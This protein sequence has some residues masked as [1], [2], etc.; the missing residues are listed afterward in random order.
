MSITTI[1]IDTAKSVFQLHGVDAAGTPMLKR[2]LR[3]D[4][5]LPFFEKQERCVVVMEACGASHHW[6]RALI[7]LGHEVRLVPPEATRP[8]V[9]KGRKNDAADAAAIL[10]ASRHDVKFVPV[11]SREQQ[12]TLA[13][14][15]AR[16]MLVKQ[17]TMLVN[18]MRGLATEFGLVMP[19][20]IE[21][22][23]E[24]AADVDESLS[25]EEKRGFGEL[26]ASAAEL[27]L[28]IEAL[29]KEIVEHARRDQLA[30]RLATVPGIGPINASL[31]SATVGGN[32]GA[33]R[34]ARQFA[35]WLGL[36]PRQNST[37][38]KTRLGRITRAG[39]SEIRTMLVL[40]ATSMVYRAGNWNCA[41]GA[42]VRGMLARRPAKLV[43][44]ALA[45]KL[46]R[47][48]WA[49]MSRGEVYRADGRRAIAAS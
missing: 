32:A 30:R 33:F 28:H 38:G 49:V 21:R 46:A 18:A 23:V 25:G 29:E 3:R 5:L 9:K 45:N 41:T 42:W 40:G 19:K 7:A 13:L 48:A 31:I 39:N 6:G 22:L 24:L 4:E 26:H 1:A 14:H 15:S 44:V 35:A 12:A 16:T 20:G 8:F 2:G 11:K 27:S 37:G 47:I 34:S 10:A 17:R 43:A 36:V